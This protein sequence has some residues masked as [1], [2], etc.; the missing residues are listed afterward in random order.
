MFHTRLRSIQPTLGTNP[1][2]VAAPNRGDDFVLDMATSTAAV[3]KV[4]CIWACYSFPKVRPSF[5]IMYAEDRKILRTAALLRFFAFLPCFPPAY[6]FSGNF[7][8]IEFFSFSTKTLF[9]NWNAQWT[10]ALCVC[11]GGRGGGGRCWPSFCAFQNTILS[12]Q[13]LFLDNP[14]SIS[15]CVEQNRLLSSLLS[16]SIAC[17]FLLHFVFGL[18]AFVVYG[19]F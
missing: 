8:A 12:G 3:G 17:S 6:L 4:C 11:E 19:F 14:S 1:L 15:A 5:M 16:T 10:K 7:L 13:C 9:G 2:S 18:R